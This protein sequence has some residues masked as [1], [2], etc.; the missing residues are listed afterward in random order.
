MKTRRYFLIMMS[1]VFLF[2]L[3]LSLACTVNK[4]KVKPGEFVIEPPTLIAHG[5]EW[6]IEGDDNR[7]AAVKVSYRKKG[8]GDHAWKE[9]LPLLRLQYEQ[10]GQFVAPNMF[11]GSIFDLEPDTEYE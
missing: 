11:A 2:F 8:E 9:A 7:N 3:G 1:L 4:N 6:H 10:T 5:F